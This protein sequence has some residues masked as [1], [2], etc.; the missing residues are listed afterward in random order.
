MAESADDSWASAVPAMSHGLKIMSRISAGILRSDDG[1]EDASLRLARLRDGAGLMTGSLLSIPLTA[2]SG[3]VTSSNF[4]FGDGS[5][6]LI[7]FGFALKRRVAHVRSA[8]DTVGHLPNNFIM[9]S[10]ALGTFGS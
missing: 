10:F 9:L 3:V 1:R 4:A 5:D 6:S 2:G 8:L 7:F